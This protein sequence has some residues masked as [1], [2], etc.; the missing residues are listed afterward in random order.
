VAEFRGWTIGE[1]VAVELIGDIGMDSQCLSFLID[2]LTGVSAPS[3]SLADQQTALTRLWL[4]TP[5]TLWT[6]TTVI[7]ECARIRNCD[8]REIHRSWT[9]V[10]FG[11]RPIYD[12]PWVTRRAQH[13]GQFHDGIED[14]TILAEAEDIGFQFLVTY[15]FDFL[16]RLQSKSAKVALTEPLDLWRSLDIPAGARPTKVPDEMN[17]LAVQR[18]WRV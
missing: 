17:P 11:E 8:R 3:G 12:A 15:D 16:N 7:T 9:N 10:H 14:C 6:T 2:A 18:W 13:L 4:Y 5:G 1:D